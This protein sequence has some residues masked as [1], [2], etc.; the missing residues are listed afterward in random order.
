MD[1]KEFCITKMFVGFCT[2]ELANEW[3][4]GQH[5]LQKIVWN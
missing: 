1:D 2:F 3:E 5:I 4:V